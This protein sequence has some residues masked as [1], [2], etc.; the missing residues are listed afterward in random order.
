MQKHLEPIIDELSK[1]LGI[2]YQVCADAYMSQ[3]QFIYEKLNSFEIKDM[4]PEEFSA[5]K[6]NFNLT[7]IGKLCVTERRFQ[8]VKK[9]YEILREKREQNVQDKEDSSDVQYGDNHDEPV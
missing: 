1:E 6:R 5:L 4:S 8:G 3:W 7:S 9:K 2:P